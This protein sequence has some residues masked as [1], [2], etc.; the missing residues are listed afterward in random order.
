M[1]YLYLNS[2]GFDKTCTPQKGEV[3]KICTRSKLS[4]ATFYFLQKEEEAGMVTARKTIE[5]T[6][7]TCSRDRGLPVDRAGVPTSQ[8]SPYTSQLA[9]KELLILIAIVSLVEQHGINKTTLGNIIQDMH[10]PEDDRSTHL[11][12]VYMYHK[13]KRKY[14]EVLKK[15]EEPRYQLDRGDFAYFYLVSMCFLCKILDQIWALTHFQAYNGV[16]W[17]WN[18]CG[19][20]VINPTVP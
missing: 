13:G 6:S 2:D 7:V 20:H 10:L 8:L 17:S 12:S 5:D 11:Q 18:S 3:Q 16:T 1:V 4:D 15:M 19:T 14:T 9:T